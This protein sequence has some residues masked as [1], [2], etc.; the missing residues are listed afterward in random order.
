MP[1]KKSSTVLSI[2]MFSNIFERWIPWDI[3]LLAHYHDK[4]S[5]PNRTPHHESVYSFEFS[6]ESIFH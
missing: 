5:S 3:E 1:A 4:H 6:L 2:K